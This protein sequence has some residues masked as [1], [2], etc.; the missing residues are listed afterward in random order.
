MFNPR[1]SRY[2][3]YQTCISSGYLV[4][5]GSEPSYPTKHPLDMHVWYSLYL[6]CRGSCEV[7]SRRECLILDTPDTMSTRHAYPADVWWNQVPNPQIPKP[8]SN[9]QATMAHK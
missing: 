6:A 5:S 2:N 1:H 9:Y 4:E 7:E 3:D 8:R